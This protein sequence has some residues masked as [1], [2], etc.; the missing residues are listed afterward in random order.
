MADL[1]YSRREL[2]AA[3]ATVEKAMRQLGDFCKVGVMDELLMEVFVPG[4]K[5]SH[6]ADNLGLALAEVLDEDHTFKDEGNLPRSPQFPFGVKRIVGA[7]IRNAQGEVIAGPRHWDRTMRAIAEAI[8]APRWDL[9]DPTIEQGFV[10]QDG[11]FYTRSEAYEVAVRVG[12]V[13]VS[14]SKSLTS[15]DLY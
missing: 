6:A 8:G 9:G 15:E 1:S 3:G 4:W 13:P 12:Q 5:G 10:D 2:I 14:K 11:V 7:A